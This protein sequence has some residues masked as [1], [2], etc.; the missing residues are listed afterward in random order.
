MAKKL[1]PQQQKMITDEINKYLERVEVLKKD[2]RKRIEEIIKR[3]E[4]I[5]IHQI[6]SKIQ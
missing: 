1:S 6:K 5:K 2:Y 4:E 3:A